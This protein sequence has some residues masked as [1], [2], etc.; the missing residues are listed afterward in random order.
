MPTYIYKCAINDVEFEE[1]HSI[2]TK[3]EEC[4]ICKDKQL[5]SHA[6]TRLI[7][8][9]SGRGIMGDGDDYVNKVKTDTQRLNKEVY[10]NSNTYANILGENRYN[11][12]QTKLDRKRR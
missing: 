4:P 1:F 6:P 10:S 2:M 8:G 12:L 11:D 3:L 9:G 7:A 5:P